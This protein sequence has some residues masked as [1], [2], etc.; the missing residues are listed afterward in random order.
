MWPGGGGKPYVVFGYALSNAVR[1]LI[2]FSASW[3]AV[4][5]IRVTDRIGKG[6]RTAPRD[7]PDALCNRSEAARSEAH[8]RRDAL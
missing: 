2:A 4:L 1:P 6:I 8:R 7:A 5:A 3:L